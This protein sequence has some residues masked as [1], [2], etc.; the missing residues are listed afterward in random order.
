[1]LP[2]D[3]EIFKDLETWYEFYEFHGG[4]DMWDT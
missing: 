1:M 3:R 2:K 4:R